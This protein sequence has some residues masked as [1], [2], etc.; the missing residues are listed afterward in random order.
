MKF[1]AATIKAERKAVVDS[2]FVL[3]LVQQD[4]LFASI[5]T[6]DFADTILSYQ[7]APKTIAALV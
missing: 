1:L 6:D 4:P 7:F 5:L 2:N 3:P